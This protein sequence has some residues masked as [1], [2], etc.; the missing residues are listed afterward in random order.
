MV[1]VVARIS[2]YLRFEEPRLGDQGHGAK[3][4]LNAWRPF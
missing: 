2:K 4:V 3:I 1:L